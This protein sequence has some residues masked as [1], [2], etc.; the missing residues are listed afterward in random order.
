VASTAG[1]N[2]PLAAPAPTRRVAPAYPRGARLRGVEGWV[3]LDYRIDAGG[4]VTD[5]AIREARPAGAFDLAARRALERW[6]YAPGASPSVT[7]TQRFDFVL[8]A[9]EQR[10]DAARCHRQTGSRLCRPVQDP[11]PG[12]SVSLSVN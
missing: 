11:L 8:S 3:V 6:R 4:R 7:F 9:E 2:A 12:S 10:G 5:V 1:P